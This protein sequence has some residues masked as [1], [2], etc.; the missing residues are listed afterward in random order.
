M[1]NKLGKRITDTLVRNNQVNESDRLL[2]EYGFFLLFSNII[3]F[4]VTLAFG[5]LFNI[6]IESIIFYETF[7]II[8]RYA[9]G[10]HSA[11]EVMCKL[12]TTVLLFLSLLCIKLCEMYNL[13]IILLILTTVAIAIIAVLCPLDTPEKPLSAKEFKYFRRISWSILL[14]IITVIVI[15]IFFNFKILFVPCCMSLIVE[16]VLLSAGKIKKISVGKNRLN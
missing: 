10:F 5:C 7:I 4:A 13:K 15:S 6:V 3:Y 14:A 1:L 16:S 8:R 2:Y 12:I 9:G 11:S